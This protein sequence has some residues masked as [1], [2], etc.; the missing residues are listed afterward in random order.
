MIIEEIIDENMVKTYSS[1]GKK[2]K[3]VQSGIIMNSAIDAYPNPFT[4]IETD[5]SNNDEL[6]SDIDADEAMS[7]LE[8][9]L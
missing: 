9:I 4:Y 5:E 1:I 3:Q 2:I 7:M 8:T 6:T